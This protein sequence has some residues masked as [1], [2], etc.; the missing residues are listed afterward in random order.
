MTAPRATGHVC[1]CETLAT[2]IATAVE[3]LAAEQAADGVITMDKLRRILRGVTGEHSALGRTL[4]AQEARCRVA[5]R[6][7]VEVTKRS[8]PYRRLVTR[9]VEHLLTGDSPAY[10]RSF[11]PNYFEV[12]DKALDAKAGH[13][14]DHAQAIWHGLRLKHSHDAV[15]DAFFADPRTGRLLV[16]VVRRVA[17]FVDSAAGQWTW[18][19]IMSKPGT[20]GRSPT[21]QQTDKLWAAIRLSSQGI[22]SEEAFREAAA[23]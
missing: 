8:D 6:P 5:F 10:P 23:S 16:H 12:V 4:H 14:R 13:V 18:P 9:P 20:D 3:A 21:T 17:R 2:T 7:N 19:L 22:G 15:W 11:L 1:P